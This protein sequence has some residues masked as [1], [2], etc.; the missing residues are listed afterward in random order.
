MIRPKS[1][2]CR[3]E[4]TEYGALAFSPPE[5][6]QDGSCE[7]EVEKFHICAECWQKFLGWIES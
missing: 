1:D 4:L 5:E 2:K 7:R 6:K 3:R